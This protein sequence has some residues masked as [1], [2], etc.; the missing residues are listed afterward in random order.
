MPARTLG[1]SPGKRRSPAQLHSQ[2][3][4]AAV[5][6]ELLLQV[7]HVSFGHQRVFGSASAHP[8]EHWFVGPPAIGLKFTFEYLVGA[9]DGQVGRN[10]NKSWRRLGTQIRLRGKVV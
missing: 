9:R 7:H 8:V 4:R 6:L 2:E 1:R 5:R 3:P 10:A